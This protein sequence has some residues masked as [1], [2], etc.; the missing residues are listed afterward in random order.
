M[1]HSNGE[2]PIGGG[3]YLNLHSTVSEVGDK[4]AVV[5]FS[6]GSCGIV[7]KGKI[8]RGHLRPVRNMQDFL[9]P[10]F[11][12]VTSIRQAK[13]ADSEAHKHY[14]SWVVTK[15]DRQIGLVLPPAPYYRDPSNLFDFQVDKKRKSKGLSVG[16]LGPYTGEAVQCLR[17]C[18]RSWNGISLAGLMDN[19]HQDASQAV[20][21]GLDSVESLK[22]FVQGHPRF[23]SLT[24]QGFVY[25]TSHQEV[26]FVEAAIQRR[27]PEFDVGIF[28]DRAVVISKPWQ[29]A[30]VVNTIIR[31]RQLDV[32]AFDTERANKG[33]GVLTYL[34]IIMMFV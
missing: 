29:V 15:I 4:W 17:K 21:D 11:T 2:S 34:L 20:L 16:V 24:S 5:S 9:R 7:S 26:T 18:L 22:T 32:V 3:A 33:K 6:D 30:G 27:L 31:D 28:G 1:A 19:L 8:R 14:C 10:G 13:Y 25:S 12:V 23:F